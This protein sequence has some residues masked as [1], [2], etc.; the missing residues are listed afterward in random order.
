MPCDSTLRIVV[1]AIACPPGS[2]APSSA[3]GARIPTAAFGAPQTICNVRP[4]PT[5]TVQTRSRAAPGCGS[6]P[7]TA[8]TTTFVNA[9][10]AAVTS[11]TSKPAI[12]SLS[13]SVAV[14]IGGSTSVRSQR[15]E[16][17][18]A[19]TSSELA[20]EAQIV[21]VEQAQIV[22]AVAQHREAIGSH[23]ERDPLP[24]LGV[25]VHG[26]KH[27]RMHLSRTRDLQPAAIT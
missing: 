3:T 26:A 14:S 12:V 4:R 7:V 18:I 15:S 21:L 23:A 19:A 25:D 8:P 24:P 5:S 27:V 2:V 1:R 9:G 13:Q 22:D 16:N 6:T 20:Q 10:A 11:S 17:F